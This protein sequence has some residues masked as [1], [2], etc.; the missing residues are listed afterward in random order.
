MFILIKLPVAKYTRE[1]AEMVEGQIFKSISDISKTFPF[2]VTQSIPSFC[3]DFNDT[4]D[5][6]NFLDVE[7][8]WLCFASID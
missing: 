5:E 2:C 7:N 4:D 1:Q 6:G 3:T 8:F